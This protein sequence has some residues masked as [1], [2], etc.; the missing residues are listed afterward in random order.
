MSELGLSIRPARADDRAAMERICAHTWDDGDYIPYVWD[1]WLADEL[2]PLVVGEIE[3]QVVA[4]CKISFQTPD[5][6]WL[7]G[8]RVDPDR[9]G[10]GIGR[11]FLDYS[12][13]Y[14]HRHGARVARLSTSIRNTPVHAMAARAGMGRIA[15]HVFWQAEALPGGPQPRVLSPG[16]Q[17]AVESFLRASTVLKVCRG[18]YQSGWESLE[19][20][21]DRLPPL[22][23]QG[24][25]VAAGGPDAPPAA[26]ALLTED[27]EDEALYCGFSDGEPAAVQELAT[28]LRAYAAQR[29]A[30]QA[31]AWLPEVAW[32]REAFAR[33]GYAFGE[34]QG[35]M[36]LYER[37]FPPPGPRLGQEEEDREG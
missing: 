35:E 23:E 17:P 28:A 8:M 3:G 5:Q 30:K 15:V 27:K 22:L 21:P 26:V 37:R 19:L 4:L 10:R 24:N 31:C 14:A 29:G 16:D 1:R 13:A 7:Q 25:V 9:R 6:V 11:R 33:A 32:L 12:L 20:T 18:V 34:W 2:G 36:C